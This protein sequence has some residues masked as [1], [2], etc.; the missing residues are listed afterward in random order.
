M[1]KHLF[2]LLLLLTATTLSAQVSVNQDNSAPDPSAMLDVKSSDKGMLIPRMT[3][4]Q[5]TAIVPAATALLVYD[6]DT[7]S[8]WYY[9]GTTWQEL[10]SSSPT[11][12]EILSNGNDG[13][14]TG[15]T[16]LGNVA[17]NGNLTMQ[18]GNQQAGYIMIS[19]AN[20]TASWQPLST[21]IIADADNDTKIEVE[22]NTDEDIIRFQAAGKE[23]AQIRIDTFNK[24][25]IQ[26]GTSAGTY[27]LTPPGW[28]SFTAPA[29]TQIQSIEVIYNNGFAGGGPLTKEFR[30]YEGEGTGGNLLASLGNHTLTQFGWNQITL[31]AP[32]NISNGAKYTIWFSSM[33]GIG[34]SAYY[35][36]DGRSNYNP[37]EDY[38]FRF[39]L[40]SYQNQFVTSSLVI[41]DAY[42]FP[43]MDGTS[44]QVLATDGSG[45]I[46][47][48]DN[49]WTLSGNNIYNANSGNVGIGTTTPSFKLSV[50]GTI[51]GSGIR[52]PSSFGPDP[53]FVGTTGNY[54]SFAHTNTSEDF[55]GYKNNTFYFRDS[56]GGGDILDPN[57]NV[58]GNV[59]VGNNVNV[60]NN[61]IV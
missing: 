52:F 7:N 10:N 12:S 27:L 21:T 23:V 35:Y 40:S 3:T 36:A 58:G 54:I 53:A 26:T 61:V 31:A 19:D 51:G 17:V 25:T 57:V 49:H 45:A 42:T 24:V 55:I 29:T 14:G 28:Q 20:G 46:S 16:N 32:I 43:T 13:G 8:F 9:N 37:N 59:I 2:P 41:K 34:V 33:A 4:A 1:K 6:T 30:I 22:Q 44:G 15:I 47:W 39:I 60:S 11:L 38:S 18:D 48:V 50:N 56:P 5:R